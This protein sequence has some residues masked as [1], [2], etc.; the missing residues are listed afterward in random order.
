MELQ[1]NRGLRMRYSNTTTAYRYH[2]LLQQILRMG[3]QHPLHQLN[4]LRGGNIGHTHHAAVRCF[5]DEE[6]LA[7]IFVHRHQDAAFGSRPPEKNA[8]TRVR[9]SF[10]RL[11]D[12]MTAF[13]QVCRQTLA[14]AA[15]NK[16]LHRPAIRTASS[17]SWAIIAWA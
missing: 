11:D 3:G 8:V 9:P 15:I 13:P 6:K 5:F 10:S 7:E 16:K 17:V 12:I 2:C 1:R 14:R 4:T